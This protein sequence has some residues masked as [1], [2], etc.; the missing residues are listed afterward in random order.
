[1]TEKELKMA[2]KSIKAAKKLGVTYM[3]I[4]NIEFKL[5][6]KS[7]PSASR[8]ASKVSAKKLADNKLENENSNLS[9][10]IK[11]D[12]STMHVEDPLGFERS[13]IE[14]LIG[15]SREAFEETEDALIS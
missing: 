9:E 6:N 1:M 12:V 5:S 2:L 15:D 7:F 10:R 11:D 8:I 3:K 4:G 13:M 14:N